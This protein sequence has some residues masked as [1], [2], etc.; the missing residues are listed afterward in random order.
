MFSHHQELVFDHPEALVCH[1]LLHLL[2]NRLRLA[3][4]ARCPTVHLFLSLYR[5]KPFS[6]SLAL[7]IYRCGLRA[8][9][10]TWLEHFLLREHVNALFL[11][12]TFVIILHVFSVAFFIYL[13]DSLFKLASN[14]AAGALSLVLVIPAQQFTSALILSRL[15]ATA[16]S[17][18]GLFGRLLWCRLPFFLLLCWDFAVLLLGAIYHFPIIINGT[19]ELII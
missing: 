7:S 6:D 10:R 16:A 1:I 11:S 19:L 14:T 12:Q 18:I 8:F 4:E 9:Q 13:V 5:G 17:L 15:D 3:K 2:V